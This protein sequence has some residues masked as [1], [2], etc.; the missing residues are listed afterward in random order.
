[1]HFLTA[2]VR[3]YSAD[4]QPPVLV[5][6]SLGALVA[7]HGAASMAT[8]GVVAL[9]P[10]GFV[11]ARG[12]TLA[13]RVTPLVTLPITT[14]LVPPFAARLIAHRALSRL[15]VHRPRAARVA[16][17]AYADQFRTRADL[18]RVL[19]AV[20]RV[21]QEMVLAPPPA[22]DIE[23]PVLVVWGERDR[24]LPATAAAPV[25]ALFPHGSCEVLPGVGHCPQM[26]SPETIGRMSV[27]FIRMNLDGPHQATS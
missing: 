15:M 12:L 25:A 9:S 4:G 1:L 19:A 5:G 8:T 24:L 18:R 26:E 7:L 22:L 2:V 6:N 21:S 17:A 10:V 3:H 16:L 13:A 14:G 27:D 20:G 11:H 23:C